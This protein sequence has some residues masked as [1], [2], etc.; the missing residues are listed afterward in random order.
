[1][2]TIFT[3][4]QTETTDKALRKV[5]A[6][7]WPVI[8]NKFVEVDKVPS[9]I[10]AATGL[11]PDRLF[12]C[13]ACRIQDEFASSGQAIPVGQ[14]AVF[15]DRFDLSKADPMST[16]WD[17]TISMLILAFPEIRWIFGVI[18]GEATQQ[19]EITRWHSLQAF[20]CRPQADPLF[21]GSGLRNAI[22]ARIKLEKNDKGEDVAPYVPIRTAKAAA[23]DDEESYAYF[24]AYAAYRFGFRAFPVFRNAM[25]KALFSD[26]E[27]NADLFQPNLTFEDLYISFPDNIPGEH[28]SNLSDRSHLLPLLEHADYRIFV[29][30][31]HRHAGDT[32]KHGQNKEYFASGRCVQHSVCDKRY[33]KISHKPFSGMFALWSESRLARRLRWTDGARRGLASGFIWPP[34]KSDGLH[35]DSGHSSPGRLLQIATHMIVRCE[36]ILRDGVYTVQDAARCAVLA[37][38]ALELLGDRTPTTAMD[39]LK[40]KHMAEVAAECQFSGIE[41]HIEIKPRLK[42]IQKE[43]FFISRWFQRRRRSMAA[44]NA[45]M[46]TVF[47]IIRIFRDHGQFDETLICQNR[48]RHLH[49][50]LWMCQKPVRLLLWPLLKYT[51]VVLASFGGF[52]AAIAGWMLLFAGLFAWCGKAYNWSGLTPRILNGSGPLEQAFTAFTAAN[53]FTSDKFLWNFIT[54]SAALI[55]I[56]HVGIFISHVYMLVSRKD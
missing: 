13:L 9:V 23:L 4:A 37:T 50:R 29:T 54:V 2:K 39:A 32:E 20:L 24:N 36:A 30:T 44:M 11:A 33:W 17:A 15:V 3:M 43:A 35:G 12:D 38:D 40:L 6:L 19:A 52:L 45:E 25:A 51:E 21:D 10:M 42:E 55:G 46:T 7:N 49:N 26:K 34:R 28:Y 5:M 16:G 22:R 27:G 48:I 8:D 18:Q 31:A 14:V 56:A 41:Y 47:E 53:G 1:M